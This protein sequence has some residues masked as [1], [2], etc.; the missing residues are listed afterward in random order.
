[1]SG[2]PTVKPNP[3]CHGMIAA[4][5]IPR[6]HVMR[7]LLAEARDAIICAEECEAE[8]RRA[9]QRLQDL[10]YAEREEQETGE[11]PCWAE[12]ETAHLDPAEVARLHD[13]ARPLSMA[14]HQAAMAV[15]ILETWLDQPGW[16][17]DPYG[18]EFLAH[19]EKTLRHA[20]VVSDP[21]LA[22]AGSAS[23]HVTAKLSDVIAQGRRAGLDP[24]WG[25]AWLA[26]GAEVAP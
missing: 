12:E 23:V 9:G 8:R 15:R 17:R 4:A 14:R 16:D 2:T 18:A 25:Q 5:D 11:K 22:R 21:Y 1:M 20:L 6:L 19:V 7:H 24:A 13:A 10:P 26:H 3:F